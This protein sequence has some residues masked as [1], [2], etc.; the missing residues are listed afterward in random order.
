MSWDLTL[1]PNAAIVKVISVWDS[2]CIRVVTPDDHVACGVHEIL[3]HDMR[4][5][6]LPFV[7][8]SELDYLSHIWPQ[9][10]YQ[11]DLERSGRNA[12]N[13]LVVHNQ[14]TVHIVASISRWI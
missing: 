12:R 2:Q 8:T 4:E 10:I 6:E 13:G 9:S 5:E 11:E 14:E 1:R 3:L 7:A